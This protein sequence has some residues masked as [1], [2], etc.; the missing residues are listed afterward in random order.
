MMFARN[1]LFVLNL[2]LLA[3]ALVPL[4]LHEA[5][6][7]EPVKVRDFLCT[8]KYE[9]NDIAEIM[10]FKICLT[11]IHTVACPY[12]ANRSCL[13]NCLRYTSAIKM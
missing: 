9:T 12:M 13:P 10:D 6:E 11:P 3:Q 5:N 7:D 4:S 8:G 1:G 2:C